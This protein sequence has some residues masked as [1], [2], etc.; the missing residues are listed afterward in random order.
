MGPSTSTATT[1]EEEGGSGGL[2]SGLLLDFN[3][4]LRPSSSIWDV[5]LSSP[6][7]LSFDL[8]P[9]SLGT[10]TS[11]MPSQENIEIHMT[12][13]NS[14]NFESELEL[15]LQTSPAFKR[16]SK[17]QNDSLA[18]EREPNIEDFEED[19]DED[20]QEEERVK[21]NLVNEI[22]GLEIGEEYLSISRERRLEFEDL[23]NRDVEY[24]QE[25]V[26]VSD[27]EQ[28][29]EEEEESE[30]E[31]EE[32]TDSHPLY[33]L[34]STATIPSLKQTWNT[35]TLILVP[36]RRTVP[37]LTSLVPL[38]ECLTPRDPNVS[39]GFQVVRGARGVS[40]ELAGRDRDKERQEEREKG[41]RLENYVKLHAFRKEDS[42][43]GDSWRSVGG[44]D[45]NGFVRV[46]LETSRGLAHVEWVIKGDSIEEEGAVGEDRR[47]KATPSHSQSNSTSNSNSASPTTKNRF[48]HL[49][50]STST[51][52]TT[53][54]TT[55]SSTN[56]PELTPSTFTIPISR[57]SRSDDLIRDSFDSD[58]SDLLL[59]S[60][61]PTP[62]SNLSHE[63]HSTTNI[64]PRRLTIST[65]TS[66]SIPILSPIYSPTS[67]TTTSTTRALQIVSETTIYRR[68]YRPPPI[69]GTPSPTTSPSPIK[70]L[71]PAFRAPKWLRRGSNNNS[72]NSNLPPLKLESN[73]SKLPMLERVRVIA[74]DGEIVLS[75]QFDMRSDSIRNNNN[76]RNNNNGG[77]GKEK[78]KDK[79]VLRINT[80]GRFNRVASQAS[81]LNSSGNS[82]RN[83]R[84]VGS[85]AST[86]ST[87]SN[88]NAWNTAGGNGVGESRDFIELVLIFFILLLF[89]ILLVCFFLVILLS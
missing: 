40:G 30:E 23:E 4:S 12:P 14:V 16:L 87:K 72:N 36:P 52:A 18:L 13:R 59:P 28:E 71:K 25:Q 84:R 61:P 88:N 21:D 42:S 26:E 37:S 48:S 57:L 75:S 7:A 65:N 35:S 1:R 38:L 77:G 45:E 19:Q 68:P 34:L 56:L 46:R 22:E 9:L 73:I 17:I 79:L 2:G 43:E 58:T 51:S 89:L 50:V 24:S 67:S 32:D 44:D 82:E 81:L 33:V 60:T 5:N 53:N 70:S 85:M 49:S 55:S 86:R 8:P 62:T 76:T 83:L 27:E 74:L 6:T 39:K 47:G 3:E 80:T 20:E 66:T 10:T 29:E 78:E 31:E 15:E 54:S 11:M 41:E 69:A 64:K 63:D